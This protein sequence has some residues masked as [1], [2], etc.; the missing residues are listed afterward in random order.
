MLINLIKNALK[1]S[2]KDGVITVDSCYN[3]NKRQ[4]KVAIIDTGR[5]IEPKLFDKLFSRYGKL[6]D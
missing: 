4:I 2:N 3:L 1:F 6:N 5:G